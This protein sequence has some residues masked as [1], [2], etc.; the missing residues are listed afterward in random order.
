MYY[1]ARNFTYSQDIDSM[2]DNEVYALS[3][4]YLSCTQP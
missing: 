2:L 4:L 1:L 3:I